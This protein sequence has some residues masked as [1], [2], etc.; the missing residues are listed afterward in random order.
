MYGHENGGRA[1]QGPPYAACI[2]ADFG[3]VSPE[4]HTF[5]ERDGRLTAIAS[6]RQ[7]D[8]ASAAIGNLVNGGLQSHRRVRPRPGRPDHGQRDQQDCRT[9]HHAAP[10]IEAAPRSQWGGFH[11]QSRHTSRRERTPAH[12]QPA[13][14]HMAAPKMIHLSTCIDPGG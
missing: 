7:E 13:H 10:P 1:L 6:A 9:F 8:R 3:P 14:M 2:R 4:G 11:V 5:L 12:A